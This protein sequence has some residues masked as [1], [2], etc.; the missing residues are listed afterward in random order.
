LARLRDESVRRE[1]LREPTFTDEY[2]GRVM[3]GN[4]P[5]GYADSAGLSIVE[6]AGR[7]DVPPALWLLD[8]LVA[9]ELRV[10][11]HLDR[12]DFDDDRLRF[13]VDHDRHSVGSDGI[14]QGQHP[15]PRG[16]GAFA[17]LAGHYTAAGPDGYQQLA[18]HAAANPADVYGLRRRGRLAP[19]LAAD[20][21]VIGPDGLRERATDD[22]PTRLAEGVRLVLVN[23]V[24]VWRDGVAS[25]AHPGEVISA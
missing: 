7:H 4:V 23:G 15:H 1:L 13:I 2:L 16:F 18:R 12:P 8:L 3:L 11:G 20:I 22:A 25:P 6:A 14:Y 9:G 10:G 19:G 24:P 21:V 5:P 17:R